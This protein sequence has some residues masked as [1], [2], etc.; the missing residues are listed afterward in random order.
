MCV[1]VYVC[2]GELFVLS[3]FSGIFKSRISSIIALSNN[4]KIEINDYFFHS[5]F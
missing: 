1:Y 5:I 2:G 3:P 4:K